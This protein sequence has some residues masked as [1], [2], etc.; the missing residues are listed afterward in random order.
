MFTEIT[1]NEKQLQ[2]RA[3]KKKKK[4]N[5]TPRA[6]IVQRGIVKM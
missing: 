2:Q 1:I 4:T 5:K 3:V 6:T